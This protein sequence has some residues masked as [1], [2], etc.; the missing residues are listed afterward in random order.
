MPV[1]PQASLNVSGGLAAF[2]AFLSWGLLPVYWKA[3]GMVPALELLCQRITWSLLF[4]GLLLAA[5]GRLGE[6]RRAVTSRRTMLL[7]TASSALISLNWFTYIW[8]VNSGH[9]VECSLGYFIAPLVNMLL[10]FL[11]FRDRLRPL[12]VLAILLALAGV[13]NL[14]VGYGRFPWIALTLAFSFGLYGLV[15]KVVQVESAPGLFL[16][17]LILGLPASGYLLLLW[18]QGAG[19]LGAHGPQIDTLLVGAGVVTALPL[20]AFAFG[21]RR[22]SLVTLGVL[23]YVAP[24]CMFLLGVFVYGETFSPAHRTTFLLIWAGIALYTT[25]GT[26]QLRRAARFKTE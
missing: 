10:G 14:V 2:T 6:V 23:Q 8:A 15:R 4:M 26:M 9:V 5:M 13:M 3:L 17:T 16:E 21:A 20:M 25:E 19:A 12:Q 11:F 24:S 7:L 18:A 1:R 22:L